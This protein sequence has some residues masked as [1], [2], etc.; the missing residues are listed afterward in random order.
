MQHNERKLLN[1]TVYLLICFIFICFVNIHLIAPTFNSDDSPETTLAFSTLGI[2]HPPGY[3]L[4]TLIG[5]IFTLI[6]A[7]NIMFRANLMAMFF[8]VLTAFLIFLFV[9]I[10]IQLFVKESMANLF[11]AGFSAFLYLYDYSSFLQSTFAK[12]SIYTLNSFLTMTVMIS[13]FAIKKNIKYFYLM[14]FLYGLSFG[15]HWPSMIV[16][17]LAIIFY[18]ALNRNNLNFSSIFKSILFF[19]IGT[20]IYIFPFIRSASQPVYSWGDIKTFNDLW[21]L[22]SRAQYSGVESIHTIYTTIGLIYFYFNDLFIKQYPIF[23]AL[24]MFPG[25]F[26]MFR[27]FPVQS[28]TLLIAYF[29]LVISVTRFATPPANTEWLIKAYLVSS[30]I[31]L[32]IFISAGICLI[33]NFI[34]SNIFKLTVYIFATVIVAIVF[35]INIPDYS[36]Y[37]IGYDYAEN[38][39]KSMQPNSI[40][41]AEGDMNIG[42]AL[43]EGII[44]KSNFI[45]IIPVVIQYPWYREQLKRLYDENLLLPPV[46]S[47]QA[48]ELYNIMISNK[49]KNIYYSNVYTK[50]WQKFLYKPEGIIYKVLTDTSIK[51]YVSDANFDIYSY[52]GIPDNE[53]KYDDFTKRLV[54]E[55]YGLSYYS[56]GDIFRKT[57]KNDVAIKLYKRGFVF[58]PSD[59]AMLNIGM[60]YYSIKD[61]VNAEKYWLETIRLNPKSTLAYSNLAFVYINTG[62]N[63]KALLYAEEALKYDQNNTAA[64]QLIDALNKVGIHN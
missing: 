46:I 30:Y 51:N 42:A 13:L 5:K 24:F 45:N 55:N 35:K 28:I 38:I 47:D 3:P 43:Y 17:I 12:G 37:F 33:I 20:T 31:F 10:N 29:F 49:S 14:S 21:W 23:I 32:S 7:G 56:T 59:S 16:I 53:I 52:R 40:L 54:V 15:N 11:F 36:R 27:K 34:K 6:P 22:F 25:L 50:E 26:I 19:V 41:F 4:P 9:K 64:K 60:C 61:Y 44:K 2:Q 58:F 48:T 39:M 62:D 8:N 1:N 57:G 63:K 18:L